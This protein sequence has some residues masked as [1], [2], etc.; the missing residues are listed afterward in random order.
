M[1]WF[2]LGLAYAFSTNRRAVR[3]RT[4]AWGVGLQL[5]FASILLGTG[6]LSYA[7]MF[8][9]VFLVVLL[10]A[11]LVVTLVGLVITLTV[12]RSDAAE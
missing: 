6:T 11:L 4:I 2:P 8:V 1:N 3:F 5:L 10:V 12:G 9:L 7:G